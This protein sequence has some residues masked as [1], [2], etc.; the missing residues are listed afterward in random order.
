M[1]RLTIGVVAGVLALVVA[2]L[3]TAAI[4]GG[5]EPR[6]DLNTPSG[7]VLA[8]ALAAQRGDGAAA[9][10]LLASS[11]QARNNRD[12]FLARFRSR[13]NER[14][15]LTTEQEVIDAGGASVVLVRTSA[16]S[17][18]IFG[19][20]AYSSRST[21]RVTRE[22]SGWRITVP[23]DPYLLRTTEP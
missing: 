23:P 6:P 11:V 7:V 17:D 15:Y 14:E 18:G 8:Y 16:A 22:A 9:W 20:T 1:D 21:V 13:G 5:R 10:D 3:V 2:G 12:Q 4:L 19:S